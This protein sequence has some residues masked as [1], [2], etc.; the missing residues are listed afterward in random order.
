MCFHKRLLF[1][2]S[3]YAWLTTPQSVV[4]CEVERRFIRGE[5]CNQ[6]WSHGFYTIRVGKDCVS[7]ERKRRRRASKIG[8]VKEVIRSLR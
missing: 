5:G 6:I 7:C 8:E 1:T 3:H 2:C 4:P